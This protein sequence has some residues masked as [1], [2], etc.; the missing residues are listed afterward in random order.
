MR[1]EAALLI[2]WVMFLNLWQKTK[3]MKEAKL[4]G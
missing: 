1:N 2:S 4:N 3:E